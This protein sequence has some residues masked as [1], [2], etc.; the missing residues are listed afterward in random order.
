MLIAV[1]ALLLPIISSAQD[2]NAAAPLIVNGNMTETRAG[3]IFEID[4]E[5]PFTGLVREVYPSGLTKTELN[6]VDGLPAGAPTHWFA[7]GESLGE[8]TQDPESSPS[9]TV[10][11][12]A[13]SSQESGYVD[14]LGI[15]ARFSAIMGMAADDSG[16][17]YVADGA[18]HRVFKIELH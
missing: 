4:S 16:N 12:L 11:L 3:L 10:S 8:Q 1:G 9:M 18:N 6:L 13:G 14:A 15:A 17:I 2:G 7:N 5:T